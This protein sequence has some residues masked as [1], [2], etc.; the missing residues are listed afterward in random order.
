LSE[1]RLLDTP[2]TMMT[3]AKHLRSVVPVLLLAT[4][5]FAQSKVGFVDLDR[6]QKE[7]A[8][9]KKAIDQVREQAKRVEADLDKKQSDL[10]K[11]VNDLGK[12]KER[13]EVIAAK[14]LELEKAWTAL[15]D[16]RMKAERASDAAII[17]ADAKLKE[18]LRA[19]LAAIAATD[20]LDLVLF[21]DDALFAGPTIVD[22]TDRAI[23]D[24]DQKK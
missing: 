20:K 12:S 16:E 19:V 1:G 21:K 5:A 3:P 14:K 18:R 8:E 2:S 24:L 6:V 9:A 15:V 17:A 22:L 4:G 10:R 23:R 11:R 7:S 13:P